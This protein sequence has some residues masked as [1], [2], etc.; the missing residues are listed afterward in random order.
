MDALEAKEYPRI[1]LVKTQV[2][3]RARP[4]RRSSSSCNSVGFA[5]KYNKK[6]IAVC[7]LGDAA[8]NQGAA[9]R[10][11]YGSYLETTR[12]FCH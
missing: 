3:W 5:I 11:E 2:L 6:E 12:T 7:Y 8:M 9:L 1:C 4:R 10:H